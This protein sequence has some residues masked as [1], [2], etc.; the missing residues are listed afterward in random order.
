MDLKALRKIAEQASPGP[1]KWCDDE[2]CAI[3]EHEGRTVI[4][5]T[6]GHVYPPEDN[7]AEFIVTFQPLLVREL[8]Y[9]LEKY[10]EALIEIAT[11]DSYMLMSYPPQDS[12]SYRARCALKDSAKESIQE[13]KK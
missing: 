8:L 9:K 3:D 12:N 2:M 4:V 5:K 13:I 6:D 1:W 10:E 7:D 11:K